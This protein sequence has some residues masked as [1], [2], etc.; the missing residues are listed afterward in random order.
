MANAKFLI[1]KQSTH[2]EI[3]CRFTE[4]RNID[5]SRKTGLTVDA[6]NWNNKKGLSKEKGTEGKKLNSNLRKLAIAII[7]SYNSLIVEG[8]EP[9]KLWFSKTIDKFFKRKEPESLEYLTSYANYYIQQL[10]FKQ[11]KNNKIG[12]SPQTIAKYTNI[13]NKLVKFSIEF[14]NNPN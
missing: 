3:Y 12:A 7:D 4:G 8:E 2:S 11:R 1:K 14:F 9:N 13:K 6:N 5:I 10:P